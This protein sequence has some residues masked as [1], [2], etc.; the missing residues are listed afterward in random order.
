MIEIGK[1]NKLRV[2]GQSAYG[3]FLDGDNVGDILLPNKHI[4]ANIKEED[5]VDAFVYV[6]SDDKFFAT[7]LKPKAMV[8]EFACLKVVSVNRVG[9]FLD[10]GLSKD[11]LVRYAEQKIPMLEGKSYLVYVHLEPGGIRM[12]GSSK[13]DHFFNPDI[14][15]YNIGELVDIIVWEKTD[16]GYKV[17]INNVD[18]GLLY[19][20]E[21]FQPLVVGQKAQAYVKKVREDQKIDLCLQKSGYQKP[22]ELAEKILTKLVA[23]GGFLAVND[24]SSA[25]AISSLFGVSKKKFKMAVG[26]L[27]RQRRISFSDDG[28]RLIDK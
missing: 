7:M 5:W 23:N 21:I 18:L 24:K 27:Y 1:I 15:D 14:A 10:I 19:H 2:S 26:G 13:L 9:A 17:V 6:D 25:S 12:V 16:I 4:Q 28:I 22:D 8:G 3:F 11:L 20:S